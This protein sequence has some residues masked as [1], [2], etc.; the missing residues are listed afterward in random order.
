MPALTSVLAVASLA[1]G[2]MSAFGEAKQGK[3]IQ[4]AQNFNAQIAEQEAGVVRQNAVLNEYRQRKSLTQNVGAM[5]AA[6]AK[7]GV[8]VST[9]SPLD[10]IADSISNAELDI[11]ISKYNSEAEARN[12]ESQAKMMRWQG[13]QAQNL[14][15]AKAGSTLLTTATSAASALS[16]E[17]LLTTPKKKTIG[18]A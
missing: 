13:L 10:V 3:E 4:Q 15:Y 17:K 7:S 5:T 14:G 16:K 8:S 11:S 9:G 1:G 18:E 12:K 6:Y 2:V